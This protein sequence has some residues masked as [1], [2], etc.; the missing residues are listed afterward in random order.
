MSQTIESPP[1]EE[2]QVPHDPG[3]HRRN[4]IVERVGWALM[5]LTLLAGAIGLLGPGP[6]SSTSAGN[7]SNVV[8]E[9]QRFGRWQASSSMTV[10]VAPALVYGDGF[11][12]SLDREYLQRHELRAITPM[13]VLEQADPDRI[14]FVFSATTGAAGVAVFHLTP[15]GIGPK[16]CT[17]RVGEAP[18]VHINQFDYP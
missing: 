16:R 10:R 6:L 14:T 3:F 1:G 8:V 5:G 7:P 15:K 4:W 2:L 11:S 17:V 13:P 9:Y 12:I 18:P